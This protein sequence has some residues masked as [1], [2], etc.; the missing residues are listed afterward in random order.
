MPSAAQRV[1]TVS[2]ELLRH[3]PPHNQLLSK[4]TEYLALCG[5]LGAVSVFLPF[6]HAEYERRLDAL[7][8]GGGGDAEKREAQRRGQL[9]E[10][11][12]LM[13]DLLGAVPGL[14]A[15][16]A[17]ANS[18][19]VDVAHL[20]LVVTPNELALLPFECAVVPEGAPGGTGQRLSL[21]GRAPVAIT[22]QVRG[23]AAPVVRWPRQ[24]RILF[25][26][27]S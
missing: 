26:W 20:R 19:G 5:D 22:R 10:L 27:A 12:A 14:P 23:V 18:L 7:S 17:E 13:R 2:L 9:D 3:G 11:G 21:Q 1:Y 6:D 24:P 8:Y 4:V 16:L 25:A 15:A